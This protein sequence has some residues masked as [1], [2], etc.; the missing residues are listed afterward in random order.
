MSKKFYKDGNFWSGAG[1]YYGLSW[2]F[3]FYP[4][5]VMGWYCGLKEEPLDNIIY[6]FVIMIIF[7]IA[8]VLLKA[9]RQYFILLIIYLVF[10]FPFIGLLI[11]YWNNLHSRPGIFQ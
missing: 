4:A 7:Y 10:L 8:L 1:A 5:F 3:N 2:I 9:F 11:E 6:G